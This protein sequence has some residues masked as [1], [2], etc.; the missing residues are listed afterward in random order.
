MV[1]LGQLSW[2]P[3]ELELSRLPESPRVKQPGVFLRFRRLPTLVSLMV[4]QGFVANRGFGRE[5]G[6]V[7][8][9]KP[10]FCMK[11]RKTL[12]ETRMASVAES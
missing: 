1:E 10:S 7:G 3:V 12:S 4:L 6:E 8:G 5:I 9:G 2:D 11:A